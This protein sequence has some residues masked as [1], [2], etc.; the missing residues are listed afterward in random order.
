M[1]YL[2]ETFAYLFILTNV[3]FAKLPIDEQ[4]YNSPVPYILDVDMSTDVDD[5]CAAR[6]MMQ[7]HK[8]QKIEL[9]AIIYCVT[10]EQN[11]E[12]LNG[13]LNYEE[14][15]DI[16]IGK[17]SMDIPDISPYWDVLATYSNKDFK[18]EDAVKLYR[19]ILS[20]SDEKVNIVTTGYLT[21]LEMV[22][23]SEPD[24]ITDKT[25]MELIQEKCGQLYVTG[26]VDAVGYDNNFSYNKE[27]IEAAEYVTKNWPGSI[28]FFPTNTGGQ[29][30][31]GD[32]LQSMDSQASDP[33]TKSLRAFGTE[34]GRAA[35][36]PFAVWCAANNLSEECQVYLEPVD[37]RIEPDGRNCFVYNENGNHYIVN[38]AE[39]NLSYYNTKLNQVIMKGYWERKEK[40]YEEN[41]N[42]GIKEA[43]SEER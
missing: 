39:R 42:Y 24:E 15:T 30:V 6:I 10:G 11:L 29:L 1:N 20:S 19:K 41:R 27:A 4:P 34:H 14:I 28:I 16:Q 21:N 35:W 23:K 33:V 12:A 8:D 40:N 3:I 25:G 2:A 13:L 43:L 36:D 17:S 31:C 18:A 26:G 22:L 38:L 32:M 9:E 7:Y 5:V 37:I